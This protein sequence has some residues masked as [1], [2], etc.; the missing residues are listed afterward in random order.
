MVCKSEKRLAAMGRGLKYRILP[1]AMMMRQSLK[2]LGEETSYRKREAGQDILAQ[3][4][5]QAKSFASGNSKPGKTFSPES[6]PSLAMTSLWISS[7]S[8]SWQTSMLFE[9][10]TTIQTR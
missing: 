8:P 1:L 7:S 2:I 6:I 4:P 9:L 10:G 5:Y 3:Y